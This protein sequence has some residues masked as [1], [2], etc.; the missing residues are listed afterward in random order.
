MSSANA[1]AAF[2]TLPSCGV[3]S[4]AGDFFFF[5][6]RRPSRG[7][8]PPPKNFKSFLPK[9]MFDAP[10]FDARLY[11]TYDDARFTNA[12]DARR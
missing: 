10:V 11:E 12:P 6:H 1:S 7:D 9:P 8:D 2:R 5:L 4:A 3:D